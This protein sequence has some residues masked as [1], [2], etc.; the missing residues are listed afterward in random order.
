[1]N[2]D[3]AKLDTDEAN[4]ISDADSA[5]TRLAQSLAPGFDP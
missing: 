2:R 5:R 1:M 4:P 3:S